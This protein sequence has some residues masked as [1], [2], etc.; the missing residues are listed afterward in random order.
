MYV[1]KRKIVFVCVLSPAGCRKGVGHHLTEAIRLERDKKKKKV[2]SG[3]PQMS[4]QYV[5]EP[6]WGL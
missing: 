4:S 2:Q 1:F 5:N 3:P 6:E